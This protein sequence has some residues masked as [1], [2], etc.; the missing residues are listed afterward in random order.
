MIPGLMTVPPVLF[1]NKGIS[2]TI[3]GVSKNKGELVKET[4]DGVCE[5]LW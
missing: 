5:S 2:H 4:S 3:E 1:T